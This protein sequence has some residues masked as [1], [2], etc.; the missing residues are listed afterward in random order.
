MLNKPI[1]PETQNPVVN[2]THLKFP[3]VFG[4]LVAG[5]TSEGGGAVAFPVMTLALGIKVS[6]EEEQGR[7]SPP[8]GGGQGFLPH[9]PVLRHVRGRLHHLL[10]EG[11]AGVAFAGLLQP[12]GRRGHGLWSRGDLHLHLPFLSKGRRRRPLTSGEETRFCLHLVQLCL[13]PVST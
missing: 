4:A 2:I 8:A 1:A 10:D 5:M 12:R 6:R 13:R 9:D 11:Q 3:K 7:P